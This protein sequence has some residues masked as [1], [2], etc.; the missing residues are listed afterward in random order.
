MAR[1]EPKT[2]ETGA[3]VEEF[4]NSVADAER[5]A[6]GFAVLE[7]YRRA[8]GEEAKMWGPAIVGFGHRVIKYASG[9]ELE[10]PV[11]AF[12]PRKT[13]MTLY[14]LD[15]SPG[16]A[17]LLERLGPHKTG[18]GCLYIK[19]LS[20]VDAGVLERIIRDSVRAGAC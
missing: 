10:W 5:R 15:G 19:R 6:D 1:A 14:V 11:A 13:N 9:R 17:R 18:K 3:S 16:Q 7:M 20:D 12:S 8:T 4:L 2:R